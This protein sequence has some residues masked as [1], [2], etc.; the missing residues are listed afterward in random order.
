MAEQTFRSP[1]FFEREIDLSQRE[2][3]IVGV[4]AGIAGTAEMG[5]AFVPVTVGSFADFEKKFGSLDPKM[6]GPYAVRE[7]FKHKTALTYV[8]VLGAGAN[9]TT[10]DISN[11]IQGGIVKAAG[12]KVLGSAVTGDN[13]DM[14]YQGSVQFIVARHEISGTSETLVSP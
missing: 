10:T 13:K 6:F 8:R 5:P 11:T 12:F 14:R 3:E 4:P 9:E 2:S 1:G 7:F